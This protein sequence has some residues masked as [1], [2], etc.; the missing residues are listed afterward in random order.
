MNIKEANPL[1]NDISK[2]VLDNINFSESRNWR[3]FT[4]D[5]LLSNKSKDNF[6][7][8]QETN[9]ALVDQVKNLNIVVESYN[10]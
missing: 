1:G 7:R 10:Y 2:I 6:E 9:N 4:A 5:K 8:F 3:K